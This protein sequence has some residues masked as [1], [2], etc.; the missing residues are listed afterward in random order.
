MSLARKLTKFSIIP[1]LVL[2][3]N[4]TEIKAQAQ[5]SNQKEVMS[6]RQLAEEYD[7]ND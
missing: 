4:S 5:E 2:A 7:L 1:A 3:L 6:L